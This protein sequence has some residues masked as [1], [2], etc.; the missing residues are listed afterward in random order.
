MDFIKKRLTDDEEEKMFQSG[1]KLIMS[2]RYDDA[3][4]LFKELVNYGCEHYTYLIAMGYEAKEGSNNLKSAL[5]YYQRAAR[6]E[7]KYNLDVGRILLKIH[8]DG[9]DL[10]NAI[11][12]FKKA[13]YKQSEMGAQFG[14]GLAYL[15][16]SPQKNMELA[17]KHLKAAFNLGHLMAKRKFYGLKLKEGYLH[18]LPSF[19]RSIYDVSHEL[20]LNPQSPKVLIR[21][22][23]NT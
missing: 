20:S 14:L 23:I 12:H 8:V 10:A 16:D 19:V 5:N 6:L 21:L 2:G 13:M 3:I 18:L 7:G 4:S 22:D 1:S 9:K 17:Q 11:H 15:Q